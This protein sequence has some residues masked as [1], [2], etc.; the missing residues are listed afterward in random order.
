M[1][2]STPRATPPLLHTEERTRVFVDR[3]G[4]MRPAT[5]TGGNFHAPRFSPDGRRVSMDFSSAD[6]RDVWIL[7]LDQRTLSR[8]TFDRDAH[9]ATWSPDG[10]FIYFITT[11]PGP[12]GVYRTRPGSSA[13]AERC[14]P[15]RT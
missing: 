4:V 6:G 13:P 2:N 10:Q 14:S 1:R 8:A 5:E 3:L 15:H 11:R 9:D 7:S 12:L